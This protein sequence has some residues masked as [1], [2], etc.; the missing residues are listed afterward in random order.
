MRENF[1]PVDS[2][3]KPCLL[4][5][6]QQRGPDAEMT[7]SRSCRG[8]GPTR[9]LCARPAKWFAAIPLIMFLAKQGTG[10]VD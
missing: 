1:I 8:A 7:E 3:G 2:S 10:L 4:E 6:F 5:N 9:F